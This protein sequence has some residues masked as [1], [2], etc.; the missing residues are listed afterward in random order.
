MST[1]KCEVVPV[2]L[3]KHPNADALSIVRVFDNFTVVVRTA[4]WEVKDMG[5]YV[6]PDSV[7]PDNDYFKFLDGHFRIKAKKLRG[8]MSQGMLVPLPEKFKDVDIRE[9]DDFAE[10]LGI[11]HYEPPVKFS[12]GDQE[13]DPP[14][15]GPI[16]DMESWFKYGHIL[17]DGEEITITEKLH[18]TNSRFTFQEGRM[19]CGSHNHY[20]KQSE[21]CIYWQTLKKNPWIQEYCQQNPNKILYGEIFGWVQSLRYGATQGQNFFRKF[22]VFDPSIG[23]FLDYR[24]FYAGNYDVPLL[25]CGPYSKEIIEKHISGP[26]TLGQNVREGIVIKPTT[27]RWNDEIGRVVLKAVS[28]EYLASKHSED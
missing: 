2:K 15:P 19:W 4:D 14:F 5:V 21:G 22:D 17:K 11:T 26:S 7:V 23:R 20:R 25:F 16:Y 13:S 10:I 18:G 12:Q 3:E 24:P 28:P 8:V 9:G 27:E 6:P 1:F